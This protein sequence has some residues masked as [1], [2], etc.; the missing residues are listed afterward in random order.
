M[1]LSPRRVRPRQP[2]ALLAAAAAAWIAGITSPGRTFA[3]T[4]VTATW[5]NPVSGSWTDATKWSSD[6]DYPNNN[7]TT[8]FD[9]EISPVGSPYTI[10]LI[11]SVSID[12]LTIPST[13]ATLSIGPGGALTLATRFSAA[14]QVVLNGGVINI[15]DFSSGLADVHGAGTFTHSAG[16]FSFGPLLTVGVIGGDQA[17]YHLTDSGMLSGGQLNVGANV[18]NGTFLQSGG[19][20]QLT[21]YLALG[22]DVNNNNSC[23]GVYDLTAGSISSPIE[24]MGY[25]A[26][27]TFNQSGG[28]NS[29]TD[30]SYGLYMAMMPAS[31]GAYNLSGGTLSSGNLVVAYAGNAT[32]NQSGGMNTVDGILRVGRQASGNGTY[33]LSGD[34]RL[35]SGIPFVGYFG[36]GTFIQSGGEHQVLAAMFIG[37]QAGAHGLYVLSDG[38]LSVGGSE[39]VG[40]DGSGTLQQSGGVQTIGGA[41]V[42]AA[43]PGASGTVLL[44]GGYLSAT[45]LVN[46]GTFMAS[47]T[48][49]GSFVQVAGAGS[50]SA[51][52]TSSLSASAIRQSILSLAETGRVEVR[53][54]GSIAALSRI[55][56]VS[57]DSPTP[58]AVFDLMDNDLLTQNTP[59]ATVQSLIAYARNGGAWDRGGI[60]SS[61]A[62]NQA[63]HAT[64]LGVLTGAEYIAANSN[65]FDG[66]TVQPTDTLVKY[67]W[68]GD[69][70]FNGVVNFDDYVRTDNGFNNNLAGWLNGDFDGNGQVNFDDY[71]L[72]DLA[73]NTQDN[74]LRRAI[75]FLD[76][77]DLNT[78]T[79]NDPALQ[80]LLQHLSQFGEAFGQHFL[81]AV[82]EPT[83]IAPLVGLACLLGR[84]ARRQLASF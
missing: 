58:T 29:V 39:H 10:D 1:R 76:G 67:T 32:F 17:Y 61:A 40:T 47:G 55:G 49:V 56:L 43:D 57:F 12:M 34:A 8:T 7:A 22:D 6:P 11:D 65:N 71:V 30:P 35:V 37:N 84:R 80:Q 16:T 4:F 31:E 27:G 54:N 14:G 36:S 25:S 63:S 75:G 81:A 44:S 9:A 46:N 68:Y 77:G 18:G 19:A 64:T 21:T 26:T 52:G 82:P 62:A 53:T 45:N 13:D 60:T 15:T 24:Y 23:K 42:I 41:L 79:M 83:M 51:A 33:L 74:T 5:L 48:G 69:T 72:I 70:D 38:T 20:V 78:G 73:F 28:T 50:I 59:A 66:A 2:C 3:Q